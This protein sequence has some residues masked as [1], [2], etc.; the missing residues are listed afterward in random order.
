MKSHLNANSRRVRNAL[1]IGSLAMATASMSVAGSAEAATA[2]QLRPFNI[3]Q[4]DLH[5][6]LMTFADQA[7]VQLIINGAEVSGMSANGVIGTFDRR[8]A[9]KMLVRSAPVS[10]RWTGENTVA[11]RAAPAAPEIKPVGRATSVETPP[12]AA[13]LTAEEPQKEI[14]VTARKRSESLR[15][16]PVSVQVVGGETLASKSIVQLAEIVPLVP[17]LRVAAGTSSPFTFIRGF[18]TG[19]S[20]AF[21]QSV[22]KFIDNVSYGRD[23]DA[24][25]PVFD[26]DRVEVLKGPQVLLFGNS[27]TAG[28]INIT[29][30]KPGATF[31]A[32]GSAGYEFNSNEVIL[33]GGVTLPLTEYASL[34]V[35]GLY[36][37]QS[38]GWIFNDLTKE[39]EPRNKVYA[40]RATLRLLPAPDLEIMLKAEV[41]RVRSNGITLETIRQP[42][43]PLAQFPDIKRDLR[44]SVNTNVAPFFN[45]E[46]A[47]MNN[48]TYQADINYDLGEGTIA[49]VTAYR[50]MKFLTSLSNGSNIPFFNAL[51]GQSYRQLS[52]ELRYSGKIGKLDLTV[53]GYY[54]HGELRSYTTLQVNLALIGQPLASGG[55]PF[56]NL[57]LYDHDTDN[58][59]A[60]ADLEYHFTSKFSVAAGARFTSYRKVAAQSS[61]PTEVVSNY[62]LS[63]SRSRLI[64]AIRTTPAFVGAAIGALRSTPHAFTDLTKKENYLQPQF[65]A[66]YEIDPDTNLYAKYVRGDKAGGFDQNYAFAARP[67]GFESERG[68]ALEA[69]LKGF[70][71]R[72]TVD[73]SIVVFRE[74]FSNLQ[75]SVFQ[76]PLVVIANVGE[77]RSQ[78]VELDLGWRL[79]SGLRVTFNGAYLDA[80]YV[81]Y[82]GAPCTINQT[83]ATPAGTTCVQNRSGTPA[84]LASKWSG[85]LGVEYE[86]PIGSGD[87][88][89]AVGG[90]V[91]AR[92]GYNV[93][94]TNDPLFDAPG[95]AQIDAHIDIRSSSGGWTASLFGRNLTDFHALDYA[96]TTTFLNGGG[97]VSSTRGRQLGVRFGFQY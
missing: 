88:T 19:V 44:R 27:T 90:N 18:G 21:E 84:Q 10:V 71:G 58:Y 83:L 77:A 43:N 67:A 79:A 24:R 91:Y 46:R 50:D 69:G 29:T 60:F 51:I 2:G 81:D 94:T 95:N 68:E 53:G 76:S 52:Q 49:S 72:R 13:A 65:V 61:Q 12:I 17:N 8:E 30:R 55:F 1:Y 33:Q 92:S 75:T 82:P 31:S 5:S 6:A 20:L 70:L 4:S 25:I 78:G 34:R 89:L 87:L 47:E 54:E 16:V 57:Y 36:D 59:S 41:D 64:Q 48:A 39:T 35:A 23:Q 56:A 26:V 63:D 11:V 3:P 37:N 93:S 7:G 15:E 66:R 97:M 14:I 42:T 22:G 80:K 96:T 62:R 32:D 28:A 9:L 86:R 45:P 73:Y 85:A 38:K 40:G 74:T